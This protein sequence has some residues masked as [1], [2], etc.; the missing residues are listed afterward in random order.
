MR[1]VIYEKNDTVVP[2]K[3]ALWQYESQNGRKAI[4]DWRRNMPH[5][6]SR[7]RLDVFLTML[8]KLA[9]WTPPH[10]KALT[11]ANTGLTELRWTAAKTEHRI[12]GY[13]IADADDGK[14][15]Y[16]MLI[17]CTHKQ[18]NYIPPNALETGRARRAEIQ[19]GVA[20]TIEYQLI[21]NR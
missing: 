8:S 21:A 2:F 14:H 13:R 7:A 18:K 17:G 12:I 16:V 5:G 1:L 15:Q 20:T 4:A 10:I 3:W 19:R 9:V 6:P 11:G